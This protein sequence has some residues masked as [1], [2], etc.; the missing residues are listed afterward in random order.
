MSL[1]E[2]VTPFLEAFR[3]NRKAEGQPG[4]LAGR[5][6]A[7]LRRF[8]ELGYPR[9]SQEAWRFT[10][11]RPLTTAPILPLAA[12]DA[13][14][15]V[16]LLTSCRLDGPAHRIVLVNGRYA[17]ALSD[18]GN[19]PKGAWLGSIAEAVGARPE[20]VASAFDGIGTEDAQPFAALNGAFFSDG[21]ALVLDPGVVLS[22]PVEIVHIACPDKVGGF[23][24]RNAIVAGRGSE[25][26][27]IETSAGTGSAWT[28]MVTSIDVGAGASLRHVK[29]QREAPQAIHTSLL[30]ARLAEKATYNGFVLTLGARL[31]RQDIEVALAGEGTALVLNGV[32]LLRGEQQA[33]IVPVVDH[34]A[35]SGSTSEVFKGVVDD[36]AHGVFLGAITVQPG[37]DQTDARQLNRNLLLS[38]RATIDTKPELEIFADEVKCSH[39]ATV[40]DL[41]EAALFYLRARGIDERAARRMLIEAFSVDAVDLAGLDEQLGA[42]LR[43]Y[44]R[45]WLE[46]ER[47]VA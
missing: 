43:G 20:L 27:L 7:S 9:R 8:A 29:I 23:H 46:P 26:T 34:R 36:C 4:W 38:P 6:E 28:N 39:G 33:T 18:I 32:Y 11:L 42:H 10:D 22:T 40:G 35:P 21:F 16:A 30:R 14:V 1:Q 19:L 13:G 45:D 5:R 15:D 12:G 2:E 25:A 31:S 3:H 41:D 47:S 17:P 37:A 44:L 24:L